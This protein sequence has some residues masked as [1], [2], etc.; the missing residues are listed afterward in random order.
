M[1][2]SGLGA[3]ADE[4]AGATRIDYKKIPHFPRS[5]AIGHAGRM[6]IGKVADVPVAVMQGRVHFYEGYTPQQVI[7]PMRVMARMGIRAVAAHQR[8][9]RDQS[10][11]QAG[12]PRRPARPHQSC[13]ARIP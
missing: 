9:G 2:G 5:T 8:R 1:L 13:R 4:L 6:V 10:R 12:V 3:F 7:F 11:F